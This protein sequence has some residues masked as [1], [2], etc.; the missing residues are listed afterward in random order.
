MNLAVKEEKHLV[1]D[2]SPRENEGTYLL[3]V[4]NRKPWDLIHPH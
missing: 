3:E 4:L 1:R 2:I